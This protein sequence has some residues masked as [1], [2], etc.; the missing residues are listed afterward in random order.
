MVTLCHLTY[1]KETLLGEFV[2][3]NLKRAS[4]T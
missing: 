4:V 2:E 3:R 1:N